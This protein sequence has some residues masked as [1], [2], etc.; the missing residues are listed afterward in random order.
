MTGEPVR[1]YNGFPTSD[2]LV[3]RAPQDEVL[4]MAEDGTPGR[5]LFAREFLHLPPEPGGGKAHPFLVVDHH[6]PLDHL[7]MLRPGLYRGGPDVVLEVLPG[8]LWIRPSHEPPHAEEMRGAPADP[9]HERVLCD[10]GVPQTLPRL[11]KLAEDVMRRLPSET[12]QRV[13]VVSTSRPRGATA[14]DT[15]I[16]A[17]TSPSGTVPPVGSGPQPKESRTEPDGPT[18]RSHHQV[19]SPQD[20]AAIVA[21]A[22]RRNPGLSK[23]HPPEAVLAG[24]VAV[25][26]QLTVYGGDTEQDPGPFGGRVLPPT[27]PHALK[28]L[29]MLPA[30]HGVVALRADLDEAEAKWYEERFEVT[31]HGVFSASITGNPGI[32]RNTDL[33]IW[34]LTGRR[35]AL[36]EPELPDRVLFAPGTRFEVLDV[37][38]GRGER[39]VVMM[40]ELLPAEAARGGD[41]ARKLVRQLEQSL[42][43]WRKDEDSGVVRSRRLDPFAQPPGLAYPSVAPERS[44]ATDGSVALSERLR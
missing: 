35:T 19:G 40:R 25:R 39:T 17:R 21:L 29:A 24:L 8:G 43:L 44:G 4:L 11:Q 27:G 34:S 38:V 37:R 5:P 12:G 7:P 9:H 14:A 31:G 2:P 26:L 28:G 32:T 20:A 16:H 41:S 42:R 30:H 22:L 10:A 18:A 33:L 1:V 15:E 23:G 6:W 13:R 36:L 3:G